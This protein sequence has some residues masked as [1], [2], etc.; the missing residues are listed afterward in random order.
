MILLIALLIRLNTSHILCVQR[1]SNPGAKLT[2]GYA[3]RLMFTALFSGN[4]VDLILITR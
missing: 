4:M 2:T 1:N 3:I